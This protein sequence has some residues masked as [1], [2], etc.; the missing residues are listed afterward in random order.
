MDNTEMVLRATEY[1]EQNLKDEI[2]L[3]D[4]ADAAYCSPYHFHR[5]FKQIVGDT[6]GNYIR[7][8]RL[9][10]AARELKESDRRILDIAV[11]YGFESQAAFSY[12]FKKHYSTSPGLFRKGR[13]SMFSRER[14]TRQMLLNYRSVEMTEPRIVSKEAMNLVGIVYYGDGKDSGI[15][16]IYVNLKK[17]VVCLENRKDKEHI[18]G[19]CFL[20]PEY[21]DKIGKFNYMVAVEVDGL[22]KIPLDMAGKTIPAHEY[23]VFRSKSASYDDI[24]PVIDEMWSYAHKWISEN[25]VRQNRYFD[26]ECYNEDE[27]GNLRYLE[28]YIPIIS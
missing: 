26:F 14:L 5:L 1:I 7:K 20:N 23:A 12:A 2:Y 27:K 4:I 28:I 22:Q 24:D 10:E 16:D 8:R 19:V 25:K 3:D 9:T 6:P 18:Y 15:E 17:E 13:T 11:E 21:A